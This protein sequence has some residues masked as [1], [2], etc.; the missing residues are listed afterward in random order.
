MCCSTGGGTFP[1]RRCPGGKIFAL[2]GWKVGW[3]I[4]PPD[5]SAAIANSHQFLTFT[6]APNL[7]AAVAYGLRKE[8]DYFEAMRA[9]LAEARDFL[10][11]GLRDAGFAVLPAE[12]T[13][14][15][16][17]DLAA[18]GIAADDV[19]FCER[20]VREAGVAAIPVSALYAQTPARNVI[21]L[22]FAKR[23]E[24]LEGG[25]ERLRAARR[26]FA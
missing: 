7:Q 9:D 1:C 26:L 16:G 8:D 2:T 5:L 19:T 4:A 14:F 17:V 22:C 11:A 20:A 21:R 3:A 25:I 15:L 12:G 10:S 13:Y 23:R 6:T 18:S 24:T